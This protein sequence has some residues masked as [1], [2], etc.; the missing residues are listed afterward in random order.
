MLRDFQTTLEQ[1]L[2][3][4]H[5]QE[6]QT[7]KSVTNLAAQLERLTQQ[8]NDFKPVRESDVASEQKQLIGVV[9]ARLQAQS[10]G[11]D[12]ISHSVQEARKEAASN[13]ETL[14]TLLVAIENWETI[15]SKCVQTC[16][17]GKMLINLWMQRKR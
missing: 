10:L 8:L 3:E 15:F 11:V 16:S 7:R 2:V 12:E 14:Q 5:P 1:N 17:S 9:E 4:S 6:G 13:A